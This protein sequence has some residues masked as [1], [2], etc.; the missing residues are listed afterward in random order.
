MSQHFTKSYKFLGYNIFNG[1]SKNIFSFS[2]N[3]VINTINAYSYV[4]ADSDAVFKNA[5]Q[6]SDILVCDGS[7]IEIVCKIIFVLLI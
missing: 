3:K 5:L 2:S 7:G 4:K 6:S 1:Y